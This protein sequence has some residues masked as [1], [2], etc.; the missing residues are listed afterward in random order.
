MTGLTVCSLLAFGGSATGT[1]SGA[2]TQ[3]VPAHFIFMSHEANGGCGWGIGIDFAAVHGATSYVVT[4]WDGYWRQMETASV[5]PKQL[6]TDT[7]APQGT[8]FLGVTGGT[9]GGSCVGANDP[10]ENGRFSKGATVIANLPAT[11]E[12]VG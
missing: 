1:A 4:Y 9:Y 5:T 7:N 11:T 8:L 12:I 3:K 6:R 10:T 2:R